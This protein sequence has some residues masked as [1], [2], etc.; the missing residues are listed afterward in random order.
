M[1]GR[2][3]V[4][5]ISVIALVAGGIVFASSRCNPFAVVIQLK[6]MEKGVRQIVAAEEGSGTL[7]KVWFEIGNDSGESSFYTIALPR[8]QWKTVTIPPLA[9]SG[10]YE[11]ERITL[12]NDT[13]RYRWDDGTTCIR[14]TADHG[15]RRQTSCDPGSPAITLAND[16][17]LVISAIPDSGLYNSY[18]YRFSIALVAALAFCAAGFYLLRPF[19][20]GAKRQNW[21]EYL[22]RGVL[23]LLILLYFYQYGYLWSY[24]VDLPY[25]EEWEFFEPAAL[26]SGLTFE[27]LFR[28]FGTN[29]QVV[30][31]TKLMAWLDFKLFSLD[32]VKLKLMNYLVFGLFLVALMKFARQVC[33]EGFKFLPLFMLFLVSPIAYEA[34]AASFQSGEIFVMLFSMGMLCYSFPERHDYRHA[35]VFS[36]CALCAIFSMHTGVVVAA[37]L[38]ACRAVYVAVKVKRK[39]SPPQE[40][41]VNLLLSGFITLAGII[42]WLA[43]FRKPASSLPA[44]LLPTESK[45]WDQF[46]NLLAF[47]FGFDTPNPLPGVLILLFLLLPVMLLFTNSA[48]RWQR[49]TWQIVAAILALLVLVAMIT[50]GRGNYGG[51]IKLSRYTVYITPLIPLGALA[52]WLV[53]HGRKEMLVVLTLFWLLCCSAFADN[54]S[55]GIYRDLKQMDI[56]TL[57]CVESYS[58]GRGDGNCPDTH[59]VP[60][61]GFFDNAR[62]LDINFTRQFAK[63]VQPK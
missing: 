9:S 3:A 27:W 46:F 59:A 24:S 23:L 26:Q 44:W 60:I 41:L 58:S 17:S 62:K 42:Y 12:A 16:S 52:W 45:F 39:E 55:Y 40:A 48:T 54:W 15:V 19:S 36:I 18:P 6:S 13:V 56:M 4:V 14:E 32:F 30:V 7:S 63:P 50:F 34:H 38:L 22:D 51:S 10:L 29:Q 57:E 11:L 5:I 1:F 8:K 53:L 21:R 20:G 43:G 25:W 2:R 31:F 49:S 35:A 47:G 61:G 28:H 33:G 37:V